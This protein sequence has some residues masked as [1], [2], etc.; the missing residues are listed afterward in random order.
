MKNK[1]SNSGQQY[2]QQ[3]RERKGIQM[4]EGLRTLIDNDEP[5][6]NGR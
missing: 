6:F 2:S 3:K 4:G 5:I 1:L